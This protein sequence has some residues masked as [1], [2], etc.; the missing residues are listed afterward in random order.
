MYYRGADQAALNP[1]RTA[2]ADDGMI[3]ADTTPAHRTVPP[4]GHGGV[5]RTVY[6]TSHQMAWKEKVS[7][8][9]VTKALAAGVMLVAA[10]LVLMGHGGEQAAVGVVPPMVGGTFLALTGVLLVADLKQPGRF[11]YLITRGSR[12]S[13]LVKGAYILAGYAALTAA[14]WVAGLAGRDG[15]IEVVAIP[16]AVF[17]AARRATPRSC[18]PSARV[19]TCGRRRCCCRRFWPRR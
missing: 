17:A 7:G 12:E 2:I 14:W 11:H 10:L 19:A 3:W 6:T 5:A 1:L 13:W 16:T 4:G 9:L 8:Y 15:L 18:S